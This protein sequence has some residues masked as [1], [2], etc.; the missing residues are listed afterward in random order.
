MELNQKYFIVLM[1][2]VIGCFICACGKEDN[3]ASASLVEDT[4]ESAY[5]EKTKVVEKEAAE[6]WAKGYDLP[7]DEQEVKEAEND[8]ITMME[9]IFDIYEGADKGTASNV[10]L[11]DEIVFE[12]QKKTSRDEIFN[13]N[14]DNILKYGKL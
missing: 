12:M 5:I 7:V 1:I 10:T 11:S 6:Q 2:F 13:Y 9:L 3:N 8:C 4:K 14:I